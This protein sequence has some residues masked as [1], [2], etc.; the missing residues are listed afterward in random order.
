MSLAEERGMRPLLAHCR[1]GLGR[2]H[3]RAGESARAREE[4]TAA[5]TEYRAMDM[6][7]WRAR[8]EAELASTG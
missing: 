7:Y 6:T 1:L 5:L 4:T 8:A 2:V 3:R